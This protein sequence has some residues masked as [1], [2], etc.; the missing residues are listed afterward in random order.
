LV[1]FATLI[2]ALFMKPRMPA[3][4][5]GVCVKYYKALTPL[6]VKNRQNSEHS[7][8]DV[9]TIKCYGSDHKNK[10][11]CSS[12]PVSRRGYLRRLS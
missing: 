3:Y 4:D 1:C 7:A 6:L 5:G 10:K 11:D 9:F 8:N 2:A 12:V